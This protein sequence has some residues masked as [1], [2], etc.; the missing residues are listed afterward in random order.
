MHARNALSQE[1]EPFV[2]ADCCCVVTMLWASRASRAFNCSRI[3]VASSVSWGVAD[4]SV[5]SNNSSSNWDVLFS[6]TISA[7]VF[8]VCDAVVVVV[9]AVACVAVTVVVLCACV[10]AVA[11]RVATVGRWVL[12][13]TAASDGVIPNR[14]YADIMPNAILLKILL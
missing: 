5:H 14:Q 3:R 12:D 7:L 2:A 1:L 11:P 10:T 4:F 6:T 13:I 8:A 9:D